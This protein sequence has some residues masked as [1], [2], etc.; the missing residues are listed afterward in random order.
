MFE[1]RK[2]SNRLEG[3]D[4]SLSGCYFV[5]VRVKGGEEWFGNVVDEKMILNK[6]GFVANQF[7]RE[8]PKHYENVGIDKWIVMPD[9]LH[10]I[11]IIR[12][13]IKGVGTGHCPVP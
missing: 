8:I 4:Y 7:W 3:Y 9:H 13:S 6:Y 1:G 11:V 12:D 10:G 5:T 2:K